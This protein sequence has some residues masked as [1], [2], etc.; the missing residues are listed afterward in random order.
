MS[1]TTQAPPSDD[2][3]L[4]RA[5]SLARK[6]IADP[7]AKDARISVACAWESGRPTILHGELS[8]HV[9]AE[10]PAARWLAEIAPAERHSRMAY[11]CNDRAIDSWRGEIGGVVVSAYVEGPLVALAEDV[12]AP[13]MTIAPAPSEVAHV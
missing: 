4:D 1:A 3:R 12:T 13:P 2:T 7:R 9:E 10:T 5:L 8:V 6:L 11:A